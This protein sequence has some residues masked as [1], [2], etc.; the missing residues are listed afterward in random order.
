[1]FLKILGIFGRFGSC[2]FEISRY[3]DSLVNLRHDWCDLAHTH[4]TVTLHR[5]LQPVRMVSLFVPV[6]YVCVVVLKD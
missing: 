4:N 5:V 3:Y 1:M 2:G 6:A